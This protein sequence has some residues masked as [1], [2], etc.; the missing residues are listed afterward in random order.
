MEVVADA[1]RWSIRFAE[2]LLRDGAAANSKPDATPVTAADLA[3]QAM[4]VRGLEERFGATPVVGE[5]STD[6]FRGDGGDEL[7]RRVHRLVGMARPD[8]SAS[9]IDDAIDAGCADGTSREQWIIDPIDGTR[10]YL[11]GLQYCVCL[12]LVRDGRPV[13]GAAGCPRLG[14]AGW[15]VGSVLGAGTWCWPGTDVAA[16]PHRLDASRRC[17]DVGGRALVACESPE[18]SVRAR[19]RLR[20][21]GEQ[22]GASLIA[23]PMESQCKFV[24]VASGDADLAIRFASKDA[25]RNRDMVWD[26]AGAVVFAQEAGASMTD[27]DGEELR[28]GRGRAIDRNRGILCASNWLHADAVAACRVV[29][30]EFDVLPQGTSGAA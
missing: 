6:V 16:T 3:L 8:L 25:S 27:C 17:R 29:D 2:E 18:A 14:D 11:R 13:F 30:A 5:E 20:R 7:R 22:L 24:L 26:Y 9:T 12:A 10:G 21:L 4:L 1:T 28:F 15:T 23:R 19:S